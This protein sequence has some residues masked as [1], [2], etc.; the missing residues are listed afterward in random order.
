MTSSTPPS[1]PRQLFD[2]I[3]RGDLDAVRAIYA[4]DVEVWNNVARQKMNREASVKLLKLFVSRVKDVRYEILDLRE[5][6]GGCV[7]RHILRCSTMKGEPVE[8]EVAIVWEFRD[9]KITRIYEYLDQAS[10]AKVF[11]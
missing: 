6:P 5:F 9:G 2:A 3:A 1:L 8:A 10:V 4:E 7:D 11:A